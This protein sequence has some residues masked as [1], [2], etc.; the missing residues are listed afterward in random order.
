MELLIRAKKYFY[1]AKIQ[2]IRKAFNKIEK[3]KLKITSINRRNQRKVSR[4]LKP[5]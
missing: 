3:I 5:P 2:L 1:W 4:K